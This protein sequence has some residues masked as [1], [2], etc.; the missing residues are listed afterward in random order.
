M[1]TTP[2]TNKTTTLLSN[3]DMR[4]SPHATGAD[5]QKKSKARQC[6]PSETLRRSDEHLAVNPIVTS[7]HGKG[8]IDNSRK[9]GAYNGTDDD[10][11][12][13]A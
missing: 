10:Y 6:E 12:K 1:N 7:R 9:L 13:C 4:N 5:E 2:D 3:S 11:T 8:F